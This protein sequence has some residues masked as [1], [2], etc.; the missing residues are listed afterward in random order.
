VV[1]LVYSKD[2]LVQGPEFLTDLSPIAQ[3][4]TVLRI[5]LV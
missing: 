3:A 4:V 1:V 2:G 5:D